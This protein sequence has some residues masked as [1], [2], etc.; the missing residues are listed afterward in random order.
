MILS[1]LYFHRFLG[2]CVSTIFNFSIF[3]IFLYTYKYINSYYKHPSFTIKIKNNK[4]M[5]TKATSGSVGWDIYS[6]QSATIMPNTRQLITTGYYLDN[7]CDNYF[8]RIAPR[9]GLSIAGIDIGAGIV[10]NDYRGEIKILIINNGDRE[11]KITSGMKIAQLI[12]EKCNM[13]TY[14]Y[15]LRKKY[16]EYF[17]MDNIIRGE[18]GF[19]SSGT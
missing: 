13:N 17:N 2:T 7:I 9:S 16:Y 15:R 18:D 11:F 8:I 5:L 4:N 3:C 14:Q 12:V 6:N 1:N 10:D 19:G